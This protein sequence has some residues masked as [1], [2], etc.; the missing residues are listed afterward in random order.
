MG[1]LIVGAGSIKIQAGLAIYPGR[2][3]SPPM[4]FRQRGQW[5]VCAI[6]IGL[7]ASLTCSRKSDLECGWLL[8]CFGVWR[9]SV[10]VRVELG[11]KLNYFSVL[12]FDIDFG[13]IDAESVFYVVLRNSCQKL[14]LRAACGISAKRPFLSPKEADT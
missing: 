4:Y 11:P 13:R 12:S 5:V 6:S 10:D 2:G 1:K 3:A 9:L 14:M 8:Y 7:L